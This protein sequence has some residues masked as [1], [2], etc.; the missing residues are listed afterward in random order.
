MVRGK[1]GGGFF[2]SGE[3]AV[4]STRLDGGNLIFYRPTLPMVEV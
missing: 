1:G 3:T 2:V 4:P